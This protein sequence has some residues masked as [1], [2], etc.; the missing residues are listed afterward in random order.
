MALPKISYPTFTV[1]M[2]SNGRKITF[3][4]FLVKEE[5]ILLFAKESGEQ[6]D[7]YDAITQIINNCVVDDDFD[8]NKA[9]TF[10]L[11]YAFIKLRSM[12]VGN[13]IVATVK[14]AEDSKE[15]KVEVD[16]DKVTPESYEGAVK[17]NVINLGDQNG[18]IFKLKYPSARD[19]IEAAKHAE[20]EKAPDLVLNLARV[21][22]TDIGDNNPDN[23]YV[24]QDNTEEEKLAFLEQ[25]NG[26]AYTAMSEF[27]ADMPS[28]KHEVKY[29]NSLGHE[30]SVIFRD[31][32][33]FFQF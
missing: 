21:C 6:T 22:I 24:W 18:T 28:L 16:L 15:H 32:F 13:I 12:S 11:E 3:R 10:D 9:P 27:F 30:R 2:P 31:I 14:D 26:T 25:I 1:K 8:V 29:K 7:I 17:D 33:D 4:P 20:G 19:L 5:K 23:V